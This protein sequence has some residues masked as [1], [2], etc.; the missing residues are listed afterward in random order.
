MYLALINLRCPAGRQRAARRFPRR[1]VIRLRLSNKG[2]HHGKYM[3]IAHE[4][5]FSVD[6]Q[7]TRRRAGTNDTPVP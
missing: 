3:N 6:I 4:L 5:F 1:F 2:K 7:G